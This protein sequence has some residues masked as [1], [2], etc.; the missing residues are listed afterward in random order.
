MDSL[1]RCLRS[2]PLPRLGLACLFNF[3]AT[4][5]ITTATRVDFRIFSCLFINEAKAERA[6]ICKRLLDLLLILASSAVEV[7]GRSIDHGK[8]DSRK[9]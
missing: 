2:L 6:G 9:R 1:A 8:S 5:T 7:D 3:F 4:T